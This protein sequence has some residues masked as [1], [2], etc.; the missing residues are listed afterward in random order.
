MSDPYQYPSGNNDSQLYNTPYL[1]DRYGRPIAPGY[2]RPMLVNTGYPDQSQAYGAYSPQTALP[3]VTMYPHAP[4]PQPYPEQHLYTS[5]QFQQ[6]FVPPVPDH[7]QSQ[8]IAWSGSLHDREY[9]NSGSSTPSST[10]SA[11]PPFQESGRKRKLEDHRYVAAQPSPSLPPPPQVHVPPPSAVIPPAERPP[12]QLCRYLVP[13]L[14]P[15]TYVECGAML[16]FDSELPKHIMMHVKRHPH[17]ETLAAARA[18]WR[19]AHPNVPFPKP[20]PNNIETYT[21]E[22]GKVLCH[23]KGCEGAKNGRIKPESM[24]RHVKR[25]LGWGSVKC[26][27]CK[28]TF[29]R[30]DAYHRHIN[31]LGYERCKEADREPRDDEESDNESG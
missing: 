14:K 9:P 10:L 13:G 4:T 26:K 3:P 6:P 16:S 11:G 1:T 15:G 7:R 5:N 31:T 20:S 21:D 19:E 23:W 17:P 25:H 18:V 22:D 12:P 30:I 28:V 27:G 29:S 8:L 24:K 2:A